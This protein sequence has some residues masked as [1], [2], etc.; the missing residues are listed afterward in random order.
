MEGSWALGLEGAGPRKKLEVVQMSATPVSW[1]DVPCTWAPPLTQSPPPPQPPGAWCSSWPAWECSPS[2]WARLCC[3]SAETRP[4][5][6]PTATT[7]VTTRWLVAPSGP[8]P[9]SSARPHLSDLLAPL[10]S[11]LCERLWAEPSTW[12]VTSREC[13]L[14]HTTRAEEA[15]PTGCSSY[16]PGLDFNLANHIRLQARLLY[17][18]V[19]PSGGR[20]VVGDQG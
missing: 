13:D 7:P 12:A 5:V 4:A 15:A 10:W 3:A 2:H 17:F 18:G 14:H 19:P 6:S 11:H 16:S 9:L 1:V 20:G 8:L